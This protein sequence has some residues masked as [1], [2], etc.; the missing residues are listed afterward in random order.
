MHRISDLHI[1]KRTYG[2]FQQI[3]PQIGENRNLDCIRIEIIVR[4]DTDAGK[5][6]R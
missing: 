3:G 4:T 2:V 5:K 1:D 6:A